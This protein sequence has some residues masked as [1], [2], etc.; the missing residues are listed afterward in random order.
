M[1]YSGFMGNA[2]H[3]PSPVC[4]VEVIQSEDYF[5]PILSLGTV[6]IGMRKMIVL[7]NQFS[8]KNFLGRGEFVI[9]C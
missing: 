9:S 2:S 4:P 1:K 8:G 3:V 5:L 6:G 7:D